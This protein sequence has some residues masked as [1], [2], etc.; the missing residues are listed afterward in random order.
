MLAFVAALLIT[1]A[2]PDSPKALIITGVDHPAHDWK[3]TGPVV[4]D[5]LR[6]AGFEP[7]L[8][9]DPE[10]LGTDLIFDY[11]LLVL[12][13]RNEQPLARN[14]QA[15]ANLSRFVKDEGRG[16]VLIHFA[17]GAF[18][19]WPGFGE[20]AGMVWDTVN[21]HDPRGPFDVRVVAPSHPVTAGLADFPT[22]DELYIGLKPCRD[23][24][25]TLAVA[26]SKVTARDHPMAFTFACGKGRVFQTPLGHDVKALTMPGASDLI[27]RG[28]RWAVAD[29]P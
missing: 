22:D 1:A 10:V 29:G 2:P 8:V 16:L 17:C 18:P 3:A 25:E 23:D 14:A 21:T 5:L 12:H 15:Q 11:D 13:F 27:V 24:L 7:R 26:R 9:E 20:L 19:D 4:R 28:C 6:T